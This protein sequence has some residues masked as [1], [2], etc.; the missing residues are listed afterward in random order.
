VISARHKLRSM[1]WHEVRTR[2]RQ[3]ISKRLDVARYY[4]GLLPPAE[5]RNPPSSHA[6]RFF[7]STD[8]LPRR[9]SLLHE[10]L[11]G[12]AETVTQEAEKICSHRFRLLGYPGVDYGPEI[13]WHRDAVH[14]TRAPIK[15][16]YKIE[17]LAFALVGDHKV[18]W[19]LNRHQHL[20]TLAKAWAL[21]GEDKYVAELVRQWYDWRR[22]N[23]FPLGINWASS[24]EVAFRSLSWLW[25][26]FI[27][28]DCAAV[29]A[30]FQPDLSQALASN[31]DYIERYLSTYFSPNT[32]L[33]G[34]ATGLFFIG[35]LCPQLR[36]AKRWQRLGWNTLLR[37]SSRQVRDDGVYF[38]Q[39]LYYHVYALDFFLHARTLAA[40]NGIDIPGYFDA[41]LGK[42]LRVLHT[43][44]QAGPPHSFGDD[45]GGRVFDPARN[46]C[47]HLNDPLA[48]GAVLFDREDLRSAVSLT[49]EAV[50][51]FGERALSVFRKPPIR[52]RIGAAAF[53]EGGIYVMAS[54]EPQTQQMVI[55]AGPLGA[56]R[57][58]HGHADALNITLS[59]GG[60]R[61]L[62]DPSTFGYSSAKERDRFRGTAAHNTLAIDGLDQAK[63]EGPFGWSSL[64]TVR[65]EHWIDGDTCTMFI[66]SQDGYCRLTDP[67]L[68]R[69]LVF[70]L[71]GGFWFVR[72]VLEGQER[73]RCTISWH[74]ASD[75]ELCQMGGAIIVTPANRTESRDLRLALV[76][77]QDSNWTCELASGELSPAYGIKEAAPL[78]RISGDMP[79]PAE[80]AAAIVPLQGSH[81]EP[82][83]LIKIREHEADK[84]AEVQGYRY[85]DPEQSQCMFFS[86]APV[87]WNL[88][89][90]TSDASFLYYNIRD[91]E[92]KHFILCGGSFA[93]SSGKPVFSHSEKIER[94]EWRDRAEGEQSFASDGIGL[95]S[96]SQEQ[97]RS[98]DF[99]F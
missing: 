47:E 31:G 42:M 73:H 99:A 17:F 84:R 63:R 51:L 77:L 60:R 59:L 3:G 40:R 45:D 97:F 69:R 43:L 48:I 68:H 90:W 67:V 14:G 25:V 18:T 16:W 41:T 78:V 46:R 80:F 7:F 39:S 9:V 74:F 34:E 10:H 6:A 20:V 52:P 82:G 11:S 27:L 56:G 89:P 22:A 98:R 5:K 83:H 91:G 35:T 76:P 75:L 13:D 15:P 61:W 58:G 65:A 29:P 4:S 64:P 12:Q 81:R 57:G 50:W 62:I 94:F 95:S 44:S 55:D 30:T 79:L 66:G 85:D 96:F 72:D 23:P 71:H 24:L 19:E 49:E 8:E 87:T 92:L 37:E 93:R 21:T 28:A 2:L 38:E 32:H 86:S 53:A 1:S 70:H 88:G 54:S 36:E 26:R 33:L